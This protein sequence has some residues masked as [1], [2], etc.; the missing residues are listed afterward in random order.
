MRAD[1]AVL[2]LHGTGVLVALAAALVWPRPGQAALMVPLAGNDMRS[3]LHWAAAE[4]ARLL[5][6]NTDT[7]RVIARISDNHSLMRAVG[8]GILPVAARAPG[9]QQP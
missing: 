1:R 8:A 6:I 3:V 4:D 5:T 9:C 7:G 2:G